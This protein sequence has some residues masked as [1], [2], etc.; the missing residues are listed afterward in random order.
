MLFQCIGHLCMQS[1][2]SS[3]KVTIFKNLENTNGLHPLLSEIRHERVKPHAN[4]IMH[5]NFIYTCS[6]SISWDGKSF[7]QFATSYFL[8]EKL[9]QDYLESFFGK[10]AGG[11]NDNPTVKDFC[12]NNVSLRVQG[13]AVLDPARGNCTR[14]QLQYRPFEDDTYGKPFVAKLALFW[15][16]VKF[17]TLIKYYVRGRFAAVVQFTG[18]N[19]CNFSG[20]ETLAVIKL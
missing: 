6:V 3:Y 15:N 19:L 17:L 10:P 16:R 1:E 9:C 13:S 14:R 18:D 7:T 4:H 5:W 12:K 11:R 8:S 20:D 2:G